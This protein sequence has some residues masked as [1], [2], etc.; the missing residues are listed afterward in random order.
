MTTTISPSLG[1]APLYTQ[2]GIGTTPGYDAIDRRRAS[3]IGLQEGVLDPTSYMVTQRAAGATMTVDIAANVTDALGS[4]VAAVV[5]G[6]SVVAQGLYPVPP[7]S[8][9]INEAI[10]AAHATLPRVDMVVLEVLDHIHDSS[11]SNLAR[12]RVVNGTATSGATLDNRTG[13]TALPASCLLLADVLVAGGATSI[14]NAVIR[15][16]RKWARGAYSRTVLATAGITVNSVNWALVNSAFTKRIECS[17]VPVRVTFTAQ[18][19]DAAGD[20]G[21]WTVMSNGQ[22][23]ESTGNVGTSSTGKGNYRHEASEFAVSFAW[24][25][26]PAPGSNLIAPAAAIISS[27]AYSILSDADTPILWTIEEIV[28]QNTANNTTTTG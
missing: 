6:D 1:H 12:V 20:G 26:V 17:G 22:G 28:R 25:F 24:E 11:G 7:H 9:V 10:T 4:G 19:T 13:A 3:M 21:R 18:V 14:T 2:Q 23:I 27:G 16:R 8:A 15:D 5:Q